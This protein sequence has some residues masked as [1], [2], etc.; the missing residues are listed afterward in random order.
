MTPLEITAVVFTLANVWLA[1]KENI[2]CWPTGIVGVALYTV[3]N[4]QARLYSNAGLQ[5]VYLVLSVHGWYEWLHGGENKSELH[6][7]RTT[8]RQWIGCVSASIAGTA[9]LMAFLH[10]TTDAAFP[11]WDASTTA[12]SLVGQ[13]MM[14]EKLLENWVLWLIVD[15]VYVP[16]YFA[17]GYRLT[18]AL[19]ALF[20]ILCWRGYVEWKRSLATSAS[21]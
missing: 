16:L 11:F 18:A 17:R 14:N 6:V 1:V 20:C 7:R 4:W 8:P 21:A 12:V 13:W 10:W 15:I 3:V 19:Y 9:A 5:I 2:W